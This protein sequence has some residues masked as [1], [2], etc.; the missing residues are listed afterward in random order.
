MRCYFALNDCA[1]N[2]KQ[3]KTKNRGK[4]ESPRYIGSK[5]PCPTPP[6]IFDITQNSAL[7]NLHLI[8]FTMT[9]FRWHICIQNLMVSHLHKQQKISYMQWLKYHVS[10]RVQSFA[11][12][13]N[14]SLT[15]SCLIECYLL[16]FSVLCCFQ[17]SLPHTPLPLWWWY[18]W[19]FFNCAS[20]ICRTRKTNRYKQRLA[21]IN[22]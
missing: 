15:L 1:K 21:I 8:W 20:A 7:V 12:H 9:I 3:N 19:Q 22:R 2:Q 11:I 5:L 16:T 14:A 18:F 10:D 6:Q 13:V 17:A 4:C